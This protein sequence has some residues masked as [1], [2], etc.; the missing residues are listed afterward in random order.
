M[1]KHLLSAVAAMIC[2]FAVLPVVSAQ[3]AIFSY[4]DGTGTPNAGVYHPGDSFT[5]SIGLNF[6]PGGSVVDLEGLSYWLQQSS[7]GAPFNFAI[8]LRDATGSQFSDL[9]TPVLTYPQAMNPAN[10]NDLGGALPVGNAPLGANANYFIANITVSISPTA[11]N[12][13]YVLDDVLSGGKTSVISDSL[14][15][16]FAIPEAD[17]N[18][19][20]VP[21]PSTWIGGAL[22]A[23]ALLVSQ[24]RRLARLR[25]VEVA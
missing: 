16:T 3:T 18:I 11:A 6:A 10:A 1:K 22:L 14:G 8:T 20:V 19:T 23:V 9:Q 17:Y 21:E 25:R 4:D 13:N 2:L 15:H 24:R 7:P 12:G 5:F